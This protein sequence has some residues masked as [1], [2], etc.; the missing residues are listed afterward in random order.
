MSNPFD[1]FDIDVPPFNIYANVGDHLTVVSGNVAA[2]KDSNVTIAVTAIVTKL[3]GYKGDANVGQL[4]ESTVRMFGA[5][6]R[7]LSL[8]GV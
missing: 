4:A 5:I 3:K 7:K 1:P 2:F 8:L 6:V